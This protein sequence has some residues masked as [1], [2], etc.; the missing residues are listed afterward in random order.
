MDTTDHRLPFP[1]GSIRDQL[2]RRC[3]TKS[4]EP[5][6]A[7]ILGQA[8]IETEL[9]VLLRDEFRHKDDDTWSDL[10][11]E[12]GPLST[13]NS[14]IIA[15]YAFGL[16]DETTRKNL[17][18]IREIRNA[19]AHSKRLI[20]FNDQ[21]VLN[22]LAKVSVPIGKTRRAQHLRRVRKSASGREAFTALCKQIA[23]ELMRRTTKKYK[24]R[25]KR[26][27]RKLA[28]LRARELTLLSPFRLL[29]GQPVYPMSSPQ[30]HTS[31]PNTPIAL[32]ASVPSKRRKTTDKKDK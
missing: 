29:G 9:E 4:H 25:A 11:N 30:S 8:L 26:Q 27:N 3:S 13:F 6:V 28:A 22:T 12:K 15:A 18:I 24:S 23:I 1:D 5:I 14:K 2:H 10:T 21:A 19:F 32:A 16:F 17:N 7:A 20:D 31:G